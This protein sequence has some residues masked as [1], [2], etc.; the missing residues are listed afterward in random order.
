M[1]DKGKKKYSL[2]I[3]Y[4]PGNDQCEYIQEEIVE[5]NSRKTSWKIGELDLGDYFSE[6]DI[7]S[8]ICCKIAKS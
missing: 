5:E 1:A 3:E 7:A 2:I 4:I 6:S 8:L